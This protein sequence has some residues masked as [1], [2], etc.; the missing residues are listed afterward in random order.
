MRKRVPTKCGILCIH[1]EEACGCERRQRQ[2][3][4]VRPAASLLWAAELSRC[5]AAVNDSFSDG[6]GSVDLIHATVWCALLTATAI[7]PE[8]CVVACCRLTAS[9]KKSD[10]A[11]EERQPT[12]L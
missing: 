10:R 6:G 2:R 9:E 1:R 12:A 3:H 7:Y 8:M 4:V 5:L 11:R